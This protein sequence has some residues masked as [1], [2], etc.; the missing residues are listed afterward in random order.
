MGQ[1]TYFQ[2]LTIDFQRHKSNSLMPKIASLMLK[3]ES[4]RPKFDF[5][6]N[7]FDIN[8]K[9]NWGYTRNYQFFDTNIKKDWGYH[10]V[11]VEI[12]FFDQK[13]KKFWGTPK[14]V[15]KSHIFWRNS[16]KNLGVPQKI[17]FFWAKICFLGK[18]LKYTWGTT[19]HFFDHNRKNLGVPKIPL[20]ISIFVTKY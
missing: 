9:K 1:K 2:R 17:S 8:L 4:H 10:I 20:K 19:K 14:Y 6:F 5:I 12:S 13:I 7:F 11:F 16:G 18:N 15:S 3:I